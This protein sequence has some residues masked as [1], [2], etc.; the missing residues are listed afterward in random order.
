MQVYAL[1]WSETFLLWLFNKADFVILNFMPEC[2][3]TLKKLITVL[4]AMFQLLLLFHSFHVFQLFALLLLQFN[5]I[6]LFLLHFLF[7]DFM[8]IPLLLPI[9]IFAYCKLKLLS[10]KHLLIPK[11]QTVLSVQLSSRFVLSFEWKIIPQFPLIFLFLINHFF[12]FV[13]LFKWVY[14]SN[15]S[16]LLYVLTILIVIIIN[17]WLCLRLNF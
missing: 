3:C 10:F 17:D 9:L 4:I 6:L 13:S 8:E 11:E 1:I 14:Y 2:F 5:L 15:L 16:P 7:S 12:L